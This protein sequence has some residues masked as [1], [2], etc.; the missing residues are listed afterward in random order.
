MYWGYFSIDASIFGYSDINSF[1]SD[2]FKLISCN[3]K[4]KYKHE[5][6]S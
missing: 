4:T 2:A 5:A 1:I 6:V 3:M